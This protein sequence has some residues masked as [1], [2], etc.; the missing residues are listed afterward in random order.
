MKI[1]KLGN[2]RDGNF[3]PYTPQD[4]MILPTCSSAVPMLRPLSSL[5][6]MTTMRAMF[7]VALWRKGQIRK[8]LRGQPY[9]REGSWKQPDNTSAA[10]QNLATL[11]CKGDWVMKSLLWVAMCPGIFSCFGRNGTRILEGKLASLPWDG[12][13]MGGEERLVKIPM[14]SCWILKPSIRRALSQSPG[15]KMAVWIHGI[16]NFLPSSP[17]PRAK[18]P[19]GCP[20]FQC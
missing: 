8:G 5:F 13:G 7:Q 10:G 3:G 19:P 16:Y 15:E 18:Q 20:S 11:H 17:F 9:F 12:R 4:S 14:F 6:E 2:V 1:W